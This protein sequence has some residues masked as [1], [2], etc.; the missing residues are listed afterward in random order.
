MKT[1]NLP[2]PKKEKSVRKNHLKLKVALAII[3]S[4]LAIT[5][6]YLLTYLIVEY[7]A[8][9]IWTFQKPLVIERTQDTMISP[10]ATTSALP[11]AYAQEY[12]NPYDPRSPKG[13]AWKAVLDKWGIQ[14]WGYFEELIRRESNFN[15]YAINSSSGAC[16]M[17]QALPCSK[18]GVELWDYE[19]QIKWGVNYIHSRYD[20]PAKALEFHNSNNWY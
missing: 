12:E 5:F 15:P 10:I 13:I 19:G 7:Q 11:I 1:F 4:L 6:G 20:T 14:E 17:F 8:T 16:G 9:H 18:L 2:K 3:I